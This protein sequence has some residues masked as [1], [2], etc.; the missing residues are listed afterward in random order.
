VRPP[1]TISNSSVPPSAPPA[2]MSEILTFAI[3]VSE[4][5]LIL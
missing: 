1:C 3:I 4:C 5:R 2:V